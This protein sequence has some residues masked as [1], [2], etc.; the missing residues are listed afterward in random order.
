MFIILIPV[1]VVNIFI[2][3]DEIKFEY[4]ENMQVRVKRTTGEIEK[5]PIEEY[6]V[7]V[8]AGEMPT[9]FNMEALK[10]QAVAA[11]TYV[12]KKM[13]YNMKNAYD[14]VDTV[15]DQVYL[16]TNYLKETW[17]EN[18]VRNI[19]LFKTAVIETHSEYMTYND[20]IIEAFYFSTSTGKTENSG[21]VFQKQMPYLVS[22]DSSWDEISP[23]YE[24]TKYF[25]LQDFYQKLNIKYSTTLEVENISTTSTGRIKKLKINNVSK[26][27]S[28]VTQSLNLRSSFFRIEQINSLVKVTTKG[29]GH[30]VGMSQYG[31][32]AMARKGY[33][34]L[35]ILKYYYQGI[36]IKK[37]YKS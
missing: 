8:L 19:N 2:K 34:Y 9:S 26:T 11:R 13:S 31:A 37:M 3:T 14:V 28:D 29:Y 27:A 15:M 1:I 6:I 5:I 32:E 7:G 21:D 35:D 30:G 16:D 25:T 22:V 12:M 33:T 18:Y 23:V 10:A 20:E 4:N 24:E 36:E 17:K